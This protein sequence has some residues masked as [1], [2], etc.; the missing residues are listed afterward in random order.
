MNRIEA[1]KTKQFCADRLPLV[2]GPSD[3]CGSGH[4]QHERVSRQPSRDGGATVGNDNFQHMD[5]A[6]FLRSNRS[7]FSAPLRGALSDSERVG[8]CS[9]G[10]I[11]GPYSDTRI[12]AQVIKR[13]RLARSLEQPGPCGSAMGRAVEATNAGVIQQDDAT[14]PTAATSPGESESRTAT[15]RESMPSTSRSNVHRPEVLSDEARH[16]LGNRSVGPHHPEAFSIE[17]SGGNPPR[18]GSTGASNH[19]KAYAAFAGAIAQML[20]TGATFGV[21]PFVEAAIEK[22]LIEAG[23]DEGAPESGVPPSRLWSN[24]AGGLAVGAFHSALGSSVA[25]FV[26][27]KMGGVKFSD[28]TQG[29]TQRELNDAV[30]T[31]LPVFLA[32]MGSFSAGPALLAKTAPQ[33]GQNAWKSAATRSAQS[34][35]GGFVQG[36]LTTTLKGKMGQTF[37]PEKQQITFKDMYNNIGKTLAKQFNHRHSPDFMRNTVGKIAGGMLGMAAATYAGHEAEKALGASLTDWM[38]A[39]DAGIQAGS[40]AAGMATFLT[41]WF[42]CIHLG[43]LIG[44]NMDKSETTPP[45]APGADT[46]GADNNMWTFNPTAQL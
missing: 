1:N 45:P 14:M 20:A 15:A 11:E 8:A 26:N 37:A 30:T 13:E 16:W 41:L 25:D 10:E 35:A 40:G 29:I 9:S 34:G 4:P 27:S 17:H 32:F 44:Q 2:A 7:C 36:L 5:C 18:T 28:Q 46:S 19:Q 39:R 22:A 33:I 21:K 43:S 42:T 6:G 31:T 23:I 38:A 12:D 24:I 3:T